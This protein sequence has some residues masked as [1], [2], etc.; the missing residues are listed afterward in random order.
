MTTATDAPPPPPAGAPGPSKPERPA[1][2]FIR[3]YGVRAAQFGTA[4]VILY[5]FQHLMLRLS[6]GALW[7]PSEWRNAIQILGLGVA[8]FVFELA[9]PPAPKPASAGTEA[10]PKDAHE[11]A[12]SWQFTATFLVI[13]IV[14]LIGYIVLRSKTMVRWDL[15]DWKQEVGWN[16]D[17]Q[18][19]EWRMADDA[20]PPTII[21]TERNQIFL[22]LWFPEEI[23]TRIDARAALGRE[24]DGLHDYLAHDIF[25]LIDLLSLHGG[26]AYSMTITLFLAAHLL[27]LIGVAGAAGSRVSIHGAVIDLAT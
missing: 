25:E 1:R 12:R 19:G 17:N 14:G 27:V 5:A 10:A 22:P 24:S 18:D 20:L 7:L 4:I 9:R 8:T 13:A 3:T 26:F 21:D 15:A 16:D 11:S 2:Q 23:A 6:G